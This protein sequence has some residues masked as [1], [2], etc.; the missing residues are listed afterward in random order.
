MINYQADFEAFKDV[1]ITMQDH[2]HVKATIAY[3]NQEVLGLS[4]ATSVTRPT[5]NT[6]AINSNTRDDEI[7]ALKQGLLD[8][9]S[10]DSD[11][12]DN[13]V[14]TSD[15]PTRLPVEVEA[16]AQGVATLRVAEEDTGVRPLLS[17]PVDD[18]IL[19]PPEALSS[20]V[21]QGS[22]ISLTQS[23]GGSAMTAK[24]GGKKGKKNVASGNLPAQASRT[25]TTRSSRAVS[26]GN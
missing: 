8:G 6:T 2:K 20:S 25:C 14:T 13:E 10:D 24:K 7:A 1:L 15:P 18:I 12:S 21:L 3:F 26:G 9:A 23:S 22:S 17:G 5:T 19:T 4:H 11:D 16:V